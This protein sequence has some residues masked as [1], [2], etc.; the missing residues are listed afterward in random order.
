MFVFGFLQMSIE[1][2][3]QCTL[4]DNSGR[5]KWRVKNRDGVES[6]VPGVCFSLQPPD[7]EAID[8][9]ERIRRQYER[10]VGL[11]QR[12][13]LRLRQNMIFATIKVVKGWDL[14]QFLAMGQDQRTAIRKALNEDADKL[15]SEG[16]P[17]DPQLRRLRREMADVN[18]L[19]DDFE[20][21]ARAEEESKNAGRL[22]NEQ[23]TT[24]H[25][26]LEE[27]ERVLNSRLASPL[28][29]DLDTLQHTVLEHKEFEQN[30]QTLAPEIERVQHTF[31]GITLKTPDM[32][33]KLDNVM[34]KWKQIWNSSNLYVE[35]LKCIEIVL[36]S[37]EDNLAAI[38][39]F[40]LK[41]ASFGQLPTQ[42]E[43]LQIVLD[44][45]MNLQ[46]SIGWYQNKITIVFR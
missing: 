40:E 25:Q 39:E 34:S 26:T 43:Q 29:R 21:R 33:N 32:R 22:F 17:V 45:L 16:D 14:P 10:S 8:A 24:L 20:K 6:P 36:S 5:V 38:T 28:S 2:N 46:N 18:R 4:Y 35:R 12:K 11:W 41:L 1:K 44:D 30:L 42:I 27:Y 9:A 13:Q 7:K 31:R 15:L 3:E 23:T 19:F 37:L